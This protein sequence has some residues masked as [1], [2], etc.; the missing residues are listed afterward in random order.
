MVLKKLLNFAL[1]IIVAVILFSTCDSPIIPRPSIPKN[2]S[3]EAYENSYTYRNRWIN[4]FVQDYSYL[5]PEEEMPHIEN[6]L[7]SVD[8]DYIYWFIKTCNNYTIDPNEMLSISIWSGLWGIDRM[9]LGDDGWAFFKKITVG[10]LGIM[11]IYDICTV[12]S[13]TRDHNYEIIKK[14]I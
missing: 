9:M 4:S 14:Y 5:F 11:Y 7:R 8:Y 3:R 1:A 6:K 12:K 10:G 13:R 2:I